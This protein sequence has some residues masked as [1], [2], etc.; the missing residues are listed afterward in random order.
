MDLDVRGARK[1]FKNREQL[2][3]EQKWIDVKFDI[4]DQIKERAL[5]GIQKLTLDDH[6]FDSNFL[7]FVVVQLRELGYTVQYLNPPSSVI[8]ISWE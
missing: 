2:L 7:Y 4:Y 8:E 1:L 5:N 6:Q 3:N